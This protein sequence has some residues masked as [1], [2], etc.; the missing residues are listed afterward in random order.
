MERVLFLK[1]PQTYNPDSK[2]VAHLSKINSKNELFN[3][4]SIKLLFPDYFGFNW[5]ALSEC[6]RDFHWITQQGI[7][8]VHDE[9]PAIDEASLQTYMNIL[10]DAV[11]DWKDGEEHYLEIVL[12]ENAK[13]L[14]WIN[15]YIQQ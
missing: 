6:L 7:V 1:S 13:K 3:I 14:F 15:G 9:L 11:N 10:I 12:P 4:L 5:D 2:F 8:L